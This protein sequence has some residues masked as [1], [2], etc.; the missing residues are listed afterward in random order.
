[1]LGRERAAKHRELQTVNVRTSNVKGLWLCK[2]KSLREREK[3]RET[4]QAEQQRKYQPP[5]DAKPSIEIQVLLCTASWD[6][7]HIQTHI[8]SNIKQ[9]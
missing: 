8:P 2:T 6:F 1:M 4:R 3:E 9:K 5:H 7:T